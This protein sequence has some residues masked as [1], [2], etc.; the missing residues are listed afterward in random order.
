MSTWQV[1]LR[2][3]QDVTPKPEQRVHSVGRCSWP[4][5]ENVRGD[6]RQGPT[7]AGDDS[8]SVLEKEKRA[9]EVSPEE[10]DTSGS[11]SGVAGRLSAM[12]RRH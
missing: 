2:G 3:C 12:L 1:H 9:P 5:D 7:H 8:D 6:E 11:F 10:V 4:A